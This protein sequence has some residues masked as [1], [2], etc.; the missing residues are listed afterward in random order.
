M[1]ADATRPIFPSSAPPGL[2]I[3]DIKRGGEAWLQAVYQWEEQAAVGIPP[4]KAWNPEWYQGKM[5]PLFAVKRCQRQR[6]AEEFA[7]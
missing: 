4:L 6:I 2:R 7:R 5:A 1:A 3:D